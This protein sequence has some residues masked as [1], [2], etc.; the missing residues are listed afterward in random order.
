MYRTVVYRLP[1]DQASTAVNVNDEIGLEP[2]LSYTVAQHLEDLAGEGMA[3][4]ELKLE[5]RTE[6]IDVSKLNPAT[7]LLVEHYDREERR[8]PVRRTIAALTPGV[9]RGA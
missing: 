5:E 1:E 8:F 3:T 2:H 7:R 9:E 4:H 6:E